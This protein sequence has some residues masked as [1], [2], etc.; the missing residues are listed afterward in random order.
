MS[1]L[2]LGKGN[3]FIT[4]EDGKIIIDT[5]EIKKSLANLT[6]YFEDAGKDG[7]KLV[8]TISST[9]GTTITTFVGCLGPD[10]IKACRWDIQRCTKQPRPTCAYGGWP[11]GMQ[12]NVLRISRIK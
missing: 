11:A 4:G 10:W 12:R 7:Q 9:F 5:N 1:L 8:K 3:K 6:K 2:I